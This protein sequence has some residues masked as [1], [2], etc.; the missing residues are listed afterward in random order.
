MIDWLYSKVTVVIVVLILIG[1]F[2]GFFEWH[3][4]NVALSE[5]QNVVDEV[6]SDINEI[7][8]FEAETSQTITFDRYGEGVHLPTMINSRNYTLNITTDLV[9]GEWRGTMLASDL[10]HPGSPY[11][12]VS[13]IHLWKPDYDIYTRAEINDLDDTNLYLKIDS[14]Y[15]FKI[16]RKMIEVS[17]QLQ[18]HTFIYNIE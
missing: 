16:D 10:T 18:Y 6:S 4:T 2:V 8:L 11:P 15:D 14:G 17:S 1:F 12:N 7:N 5:L 9:L 3:T 13:I